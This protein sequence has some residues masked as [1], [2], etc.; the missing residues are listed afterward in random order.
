MTEVQSATTSLPQAA[1]ATERPRSRYLARVLAEATCTVALAVSD[2]AGACLSVAVAYG[3]HRLLTTWLTLK[4]LSLAHG[5]G[6]A[7]WLAIPLLAV[8]LLRGTY[9]RKVPFWEAARLLLGSVV[10]AIVVSFIGLYLTRLAPEMSRSLFVLSGVAMVA[11]V[12]LLRLSCVALLYRLKLWG[13]E[14]AVVGHATHVHTVAA[15]LER[16]H[17]LG[18]HVVQTIEVTGD[19]KELMPRTNAAIVVMEGLAPEAASRLV[20]ALHAVIRRVTIMPVLTELPYAWTTPHFLL[21]RRYMLLTTDNRLKEPVNLLLKRVF[22]FVLA[23]LMTVL[24]APFFLLMALAIRLESSGPAFFAHKRIGRRGRTFPCLKFRTMYADAQ[25]R[26]QSILDADPAKQAEWDATYKLKDDPRITGVGRFLRKTS[27]D[28]FPQLFN[29]LAGQ[30]SLVG[31]RPIVE[32]EIAKY[33]DGYAVYSEV[34]PG[35][36]GLWQVSGRTETSY[37][38]RVAIDVCYVCN[39]SLW[40]DLVVL[41]RTIPA[42][43]SK[44]GAY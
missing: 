3:I 27:L 22:D 11:I 16:D 35:I 40:L 42:V 30:M 15:N 1:H 41:L 33:G 14:V 29:V 43:L 37:A 26:L 28:E 38:E 18:Y 8:S 17:M 4:P 34:T 39:W 21:D 20:S 36:T 5:L 24:L 25:Q 32:G 2:L 19:E 23:A 31:P 13:Q 10:V 9:T 44:R 12:P 7:I 6:N